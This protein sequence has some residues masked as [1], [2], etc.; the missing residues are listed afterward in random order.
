MFS[1][2]LYM[3]LSFKRNALYTFTPNSIYSSIDCVLN[4]KENFKAKAGMTHTSLH[5]WNRTFSSLLQQ[6]LN[7]RI[8]FTVM[9]TKKITKVCIQFLYF[10]FNIFW[11][12]C[13]SFL[14]F[15]WNAGSFAYIQKLG[16]AFKHPVQS[17]VPLKI[18]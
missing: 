13:I 9:F 2:V 1:K 4:K 10:S 15:N 11:V 3:F 8:F 14:F 18:K 17:V 5:K 16:P 6:K 7:N 12:S